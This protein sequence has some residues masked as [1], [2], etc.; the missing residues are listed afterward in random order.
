MFCQQDLNLFLIRFFLN[1]FATIKIKF[2]LNEIVMTVG[3]AK[4][5]DSNEKQVKRRIFAVICTLLP[6]RSSQSFLSWI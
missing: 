6:M 1:Q 4:A 3:E 2:R 5:Y